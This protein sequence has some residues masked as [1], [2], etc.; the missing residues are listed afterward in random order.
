MFELPNIL[1]ENK[2]LPTKYLIFQDET[3]YR[4]AEWF[5]LERDGRNYSHNILHQ[6]SKGLQ[7]FTKVSDK[8]SKFD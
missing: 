6:L 5:H 7:N 8:G 4:H 1:H 2:L 3:V